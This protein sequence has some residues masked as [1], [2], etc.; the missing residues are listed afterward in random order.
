MYPDRASCQQK[1]NDKLESLGYPS[2][3]LHPGE[4]CAGGADLNSDHT[5]MTRCDDN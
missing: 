2:I 5:K 4:I 1:I 3:E